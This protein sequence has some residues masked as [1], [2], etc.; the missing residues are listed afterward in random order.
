[1]DQPSEPESQII[2]IL[3]NLQILFDRE[4]KFD[5]LRSKSDHSMLPVDF[6]LNI[7]GFLAIIEYNGAQHYSP[8]NNSETAKSAFR[9]LSA[10]GT[11]RLNFCEK[12]N[13]P[14]LIIHYKDKHQLQK[15]IEAFI[16]DIKNDL[17][18]HTQKYTTHTKGFFHDLPYCAFRS[19]PDGP[20][21]PLQFQENSQLGYLSLSS[22]AIVWTK[23]ELNTLLARI[24]EYQQK[25]E[26]YQT[27]TANLVLNIDSLRKELIEKD[28]LL[29]ASQKS[30]PNQPIKKT[31]ENIK[32]T[33]KFRMTNSPRSRLTSDARVFI[34]SLSSKY[35]EIS[36]LQECLEKNYNEKISIPTL[37]KCTES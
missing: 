22:D 12:N 10:N 15:I 16:E 24:E 28:K 34:K 14:L 21:S 6:A 35:K 13:I 23:T 20:I 26:Q 36:A 29:A 3:N 31:S 4:R 18:N 11:A 37:K 2:G 27:I 30:L 25:V 8:K 33:G 1:M 17:H 7:N 9:R 19:T 5:D 32:F